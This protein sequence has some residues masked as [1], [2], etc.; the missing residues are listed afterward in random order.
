MLP[1]LID[2][3]EEL[4]EMA[5]R[6]GKQFKVLADEIWRDMMRLQGRPRGEWRQFRDRPSSPSSPVSSQQRG[7]RELQMLPGESRG[8]LDRLVR[9]SYKGRQRMKQGEGGPIVE[10]YQQQK[11]SNWEMYTKKTPF[12]GI[13]ATTMLPIVPQANALPP[14]TVSNSPATTTTTTTARTTPT[15]RTYAPNGIAFAQGVSIYDEDA[16]LLRATTTTQSNSGPRKQQRV[17]PTKCAKG[18]PGYP[19]KPG[20]DGIPGVPGSHGKKGESG[21][22]VQRQFENGASRCVVCPAG[23]FGSPGAMGLPGENGENGASGVPGVAKRAP[24]GAPGPVGDVGPPGRDGTVGIAGKPGSP[25]TKYMKGKPGPKGKSGQ[26]GESGVPGDD[27][28][29]GSPGSTGE[30]GYRGW[31]GEVGPAGKPGSIG[32]VGIQGIPGAERH[33]CNCPVRSSQLMRL[34]DQPGGVEGN[35]GRWKGRH[36]N[37]LLN[38]FEKYTRENEKEKGP[39]QK[40]QDKARTAAGIL[41]TD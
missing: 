17:T 2:E 40:G 31:P 11:P 38:E 24:S 32:L 7:R 3:L 16:S 18:P 36:P 8:F 25:G 35:F 4:N 13:F 28:I 22:A 23:Q 39:A 12:G 1:M 5:S 19:G 34:K 6:E 37:Q 29:D 33:Y 20:H 30:V 14:V 26:V 10:Q 9:K 27:G 15:K 41:E 21:D